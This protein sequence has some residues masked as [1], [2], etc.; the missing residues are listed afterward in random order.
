MCGYSLRQRHSI[1]HKFCREFV[2]VF[3][4]GRSTWQVKLE[5][6]SFR[7]KHSTLLTSL[8]CRVHFNHN[9][10]RKTFFRSNKLRAWQFTKCSQLW[11]RPAACEHASSAYEVRNF[12]NLQN[13]IIECTVIS[14]SFGIRRRN[15]HEMNAEQYF[16]NQYWF[17]YN[18]FPACATEWE[19]DTLNRCP[20]AV[21]L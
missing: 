15:P 12:N 14:A 5:S 8:S 13:R 16:I 18:G 19:S 7:F 6:T 21:E 3:R 1:E 20:V 17:C 9:Y 10:A 11:N 4:C 2:A